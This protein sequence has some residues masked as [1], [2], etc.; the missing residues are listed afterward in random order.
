MKDLL[1]ALGFELYDEALGDGGELLQGLEEFREHLGGQ[2]TITMLR[3]IG[4][5]VDVHEINFGVMRE[6]IRS[7][8]PTENPVSV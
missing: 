1:V 5:P 7:L 8:S 2:L 6:A 3:E 4:K